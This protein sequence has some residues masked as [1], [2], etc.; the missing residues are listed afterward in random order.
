M[1][2][3]E[4]LARDIARASHQQGDFTGWFDTLYRRS[5]RDNTR[6]PWANLAPNALLVEWL[7]R[8]NED[9]RGRSAL[10]IGCGL[11]DDAEELA[12][13][14]FE[15]VAFDVSDTAAAWCRE[16]FPKTEVEYA[17]ADVL[18][19][20][21]DW[22]N[23]FDFVFEAYTIQ[24]LPLDLRLRT[25]DAVADTVAPKGALLVI[26]AGC[27]EGE[28]R[29]RIPWPLTRS[30]LNR[31]QERGLEE[32]VFEDTTTPGDPPV[33]RFLTYCTRENV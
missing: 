31:F 30:E 12:R 22:R 2:K 18:D 5:D 8:Q 3:D 10:V 26:G 14:G 33:R 15:V 20:P 29:P 32:R 23:R 13:R 9:G 27:D 4:T 17:Q 6:I 21:R 25:L 11:G 28:E 16:R 7:D 24:S 1:P 19:L